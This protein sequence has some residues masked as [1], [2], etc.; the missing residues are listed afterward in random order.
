MW[1]S[2]QARAAVHSELLQH[3]QLFTATQSTCGLSTQKL[4]AL[5]QRCPAGRGCID[6]SLS[7]ATASPEDY[8]AVAP[9]ALQSSSRHSTCGSNA[10]ISSGRCGR[11]GRAARAEQELMDCSNDMGSLA[12]VFS[13][14]MGAHIQAFSAAM[15]RRPN[16]LVGD[17]PPHVSFRLGTGQPVMPGQAASSAKWLQFRWQPVRWRQG[18]R[19]GQGQ[20]PPTETNVNTRRWG[21]CGRCMK[22]LLPCE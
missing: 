9:V 4:D 18:Q 7:F 14:Q 15:M 1:L 16:V 22:I 2:Q 19:Q 13:M 3:G 8:A 20:R 11:S 12:T 10:S 6:I 21:V 5:L 17:A